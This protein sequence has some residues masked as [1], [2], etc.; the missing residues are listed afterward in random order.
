LSADQDFKRVYKNCMR[1]RGHNII[2]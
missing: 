1:N 2:D